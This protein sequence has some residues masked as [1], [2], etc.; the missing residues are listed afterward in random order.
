MHISCFTFLVEKQTQSTLKWHI[1]GTSE[2]K[3]SQDKHG[4]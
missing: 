4:S 3:D 1:Y 2:E